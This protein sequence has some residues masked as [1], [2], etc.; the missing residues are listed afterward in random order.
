MNAALP[1]GWN[2]IDEGGVQFDELGLPLDQRFMR[3]PRPAPPARALALSLCELACEGE[4]RVV[5][6]SL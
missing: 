5:L 1:Y 2:W 3:A 4:G 6:T